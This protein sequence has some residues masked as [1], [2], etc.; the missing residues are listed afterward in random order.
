MTEQI[1]QLT[2]EQIDKHWAVV[3]ARLDPL[4]KIVPGSNMD[5]ARAV[6]DARDTID[7]LLTAVGNYERARATAAEKGLLDE[8]TGQLKAKLASEGKQ[9]MLRRVVE[10]ETPPAPVPDPQ[11]L[12]ERSPK[13]AKRRAKPNVRARA[14]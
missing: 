11:P 6:C 1:E 14:K 12:P 9:P 10:P 4:L 7:R 3:R 5:D 13:A 2:L 8:A